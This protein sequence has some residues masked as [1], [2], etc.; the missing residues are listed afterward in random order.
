[1]FQ[2]YLTDLAEKK[3]LCK[4]SEFSLHF[5]KGLTAIAAAIFNGTQW[6]DDVSWLHDWLKVKC[7]SKS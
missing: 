1:M 2:M 7:D 6:D 5:P 3:L 4:R